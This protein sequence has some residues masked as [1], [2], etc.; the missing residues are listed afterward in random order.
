MTF[1]PLKVSGCSMSE[2]GGLVDLPASESPPASS[3]FWGHV[4]SDTMFL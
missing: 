1:F 3:C 4:L 2:K